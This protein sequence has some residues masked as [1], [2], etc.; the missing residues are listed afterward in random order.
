VELWPLF[1]QYRSWEAILRRFYLRIAKDNAAA[2]TRLT[3][4]LTSGLFL[5]VMQ[6][7][8]EKDRSSIA[9]H[10]PTQPVLGSPSVNSLDQEVR[11]NFPT[12]PNK[13]IEQF[14]SFTHECV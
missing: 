11:A 12:A 3:Q 1:Q 4:V 9:S 10:T 5:G 13:T 6:K 7:I 14:Q 2:A 8:V